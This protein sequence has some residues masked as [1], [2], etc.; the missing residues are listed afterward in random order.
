MG[1]YTK[2][3]EDGGKWV[4]IGTDG[5]GL[6]AAVIND[7]SSNYN[8]K[9][10]GVVIDG[11]TY[12]IY[13]FTDETANDLSLT[14]DTPG[15]VDALIVA[16]GGGGGGGQ[17]AGKGGGGAGGLINTSLLV[18]AHTYEV[19]VGNGGAGGGDAN[20]PSGGATGGNSIAFGLTAH[21]GGGG[22]YSPSY[23]TGVITAGGV[24]GSGGGGNPP[25]STLPYLSS[26]GH[27]G[28]GLGGGGAGGQNGNEGGPG[29]ILDFD[30]QGD[31]EYAMGGNSNTP[32]APTTP[33]S[34]GKAGA[35]YA[36]GNAGKNGIVIVRVEV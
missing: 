34:G 29:I 23:N 28:D 21:G 27:D 8:N 31:V 18:D 35:A 25:G 20:S 5:G 12:D 6:S 1:I 30:L 26:Q 2:I 33:G 16:G 32:D 4:E 7:A 9:D 14:V 36:A 13:T 15:L 10:S 17:N 19:K 11:K 3:S 24:G 22:G